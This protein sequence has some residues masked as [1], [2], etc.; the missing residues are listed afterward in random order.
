MYLG[1]AVLGGHLVLELRVRGTNGP[2]A[3]CPGGG[4][5]GGL[6]Y[7]DNWPGDTIYVIQNKKP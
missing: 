1:S 6:S 3:S 2:R 4:V 7:Y 5:G